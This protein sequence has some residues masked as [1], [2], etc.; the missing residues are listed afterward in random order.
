MKAIGIDLGTTNSVAAVGGKNPK[1][2]PSNA[3]EQLTPSVVSF[4]RKKRSENGE[5]VVGRSAINNAVRDPENT[6]FSVKRLMGRVYGEPRIEDVRQRF[7][8]RVAEPPDSDTQDQGVRVLLNDQPYTPVQI[9]AMILKDVKS[10]AEVA[11]GEPVTHAVITVPAYFEER[12]RKATAE[13]GAAAGL[14]VIEVIDEPTAAAIAFGISREDERHRVL[15]YD[16]GGGT[17]DISI[18][19]MTKGN[20]SVLEIA[21]NNWLGGDDFD[22]TIITR[23]I[24]WVHE[25]Y[26]YDPSNDKAFLAKAKVEAER[27][28]IALG[29]QQ[30][31]EISVPFMVNVPNLGPVELDMELTREQFFSDIHPLVSETI[32]LVRGAMA[33][34]GLTVDDIT[35][36]LL[37][38]GS[39]AVPLVQQEMYDLFGQ[40]KVKRHVNPMECV[41]LGAGILAAGVVLEDEGIPTRQPDAPRVQ[42]VTAMNLGIGAVRGDNPDA[43]IPIIPKGTAYPLAQ[44]MKRIFVPAEENQTLIRVPVYEGLNERASLNEQQGIIEFPLPEAIGSSQQ[45]EVTFNYD[46]NRVLT[47]GIRVL[48]TDH[49]VQQVLQRDRA[50][51]Q[52]QRP[53]DLTTDFREELQPSIRAAEHF[54]ETYGDYMT[55]EDRQEIREALAEGNTALRKNDESMGSRATLMLRNKLMGSGVAS[56]LFIAERAMH[57]LPEAQ[58]QVLAQAVA[59]LRT[60]VR[61]R[62]ETDISRLSTELR[63]AIAALM[64]R[65]SAAM[66]V[67]DR[68]GLDDLLRDVYGRSAS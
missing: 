35:E 32:D 9:S 63:V 6:I 14:K 26:D 36:V 12:Q 31:V 50:R 52:V 43:F 57:G 27:A 48:G 28:K 24:A 47:V 13:A 39:T 49:F 8:Y 2:L 30:S 58:S 38:G 18:I 22:H 19:Q 65:R 62:N 68:K 44:P 23:M 10:S 40:T 33:K 64:E 3:N 45:V 51:M 46:A 15:V 29:A 67:E 25:E 42:G 20:Y 41:A 55:E 16:L 4:V 37:V 56:L 34:Q 1:V 61:R 11:L 17:F 53:D 54:L 60:A 7:N 59:S 21:G 5:I 66:P